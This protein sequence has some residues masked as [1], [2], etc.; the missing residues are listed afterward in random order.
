MGQPVGFEN[1]SRRTPV[2]G[3]EELD[4]GAALC[5]S[6]PASISCASEVNQRHVRVAEAW[7]MHAGCHRRQLLAPCRRHTLV[8]VVED[9]ISSTVRAGKFCL[10]CISFLSL[11]YSTV[12][13]MPSVPSSAF[14]TSVVRC[15]PTL[16]GRR[17]VIQPWRMHYG[18]VHLDSETAMPSVAEEAAVDTRAKQPWHSPDNTSAHT[19]DESC[20]W[21]N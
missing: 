20:G 14:A 8:V 13:A 4:F 21:T 1:R 16:Q 7:F 15:S 2:R 19:D 17:F 10:T 11:R 3:F 5:S 6:P 12:A 9:C 18:P